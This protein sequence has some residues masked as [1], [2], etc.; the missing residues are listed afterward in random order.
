MHKQQINKNIAIA[1]ALLADSKSGRYDNPRI[2]HSQRNL[3]TEAVIELLAKLLV[4][5]DQK[6]DSIISKNPDIFNPPDEL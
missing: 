3:I 5:P 1:I 6:A 2:T 4:S